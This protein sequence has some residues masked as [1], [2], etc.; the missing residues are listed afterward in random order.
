VENTVVSL[1]PYPLYITGEHNFFNSFTKEIGSCSPAR[2][3]NFKFE[4]DGISSILLTS[5]C[6]LEGVV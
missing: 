1:G 2:V 5:N 3:I 4:R 6:I